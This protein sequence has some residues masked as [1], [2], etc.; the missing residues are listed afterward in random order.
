MKLLVVCSSLDLHTPLSATPAWWQLLKALYEEGV[1]LL[2]TTYHGSAPETL[3]WRPYPNPARWQGDLYAALRRA[4]RRIRGV[5]GRARAGAGA[6]E[7]LRQ[8]AVRGLAQAVIAPPWRRHLFAILE[9]Q[10]DVDAVLLVSVPPNHLRGV[11]GAIRKRFGVPVAFYDGD[12]PASLPPYQGFATGF[13]IY[14]GADLAEFSA[15]ISNSLGGEAAL[16]ALGAAVVHTLYYAADPQVY[17]PFSVDQD[18]DV[19]FYGHTTE[20]RQGELDKMLVAPKAALPDRRFA[21]RGVGLG[22]LPGVELLPYLS[23][24][25][26]RGCIARSRVNLV[27]GRRP[28]TELYASSTMRPFE[29]AMMGACMVS[30]PCLGMQEWFEPEKEIIIVGSAQEAAERYRYLLDHES[31]RRKLGQA[32]RARALAEHTYRHRARRLVQ[33][34]SGLH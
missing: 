1:E 18:I 27:I 6:E 31:V 17:E 16:R 10:R 7:S 19:F 21:A 26:L 9:D 13:A 15:V 24:S 5:E 22:T 32:A 3:W 28:H 8:R 12:V 2:V 30:N 34:L 11:A 25:D 33:I 29:L 23:F 4:A 14:A 20:Y